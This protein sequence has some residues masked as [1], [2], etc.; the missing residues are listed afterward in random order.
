MGYSMGDIKNQEK[1]RSMGLSPADA[2]VYEL[3]EISSPEQRMSMSSCPDHEAH[4]PAHHKDY[5]PEPELF[6]E[7]SQAQCKAETE[8]P[9][10]HTDYPS[11]RC[12][13]FNGDQHPKYSYDGLPLHPD[14]D[15]AMDNDYANDN[16]FLPSDSNMLQ[17]LPSMEVD[18]SPSRNPRASGK[19]KE[20]H[21]T[22]PSGEKIKLTPSERI[23][24]RS[25]YDDLTYDPKSTDYKFTTAAQLLEPKAFDALGW[26]PEHY[27]GLTNTIPVPASAYTA[28][29]EPSAAADQPVPPRRTVYTTNRDLALMVGWMRKPITRMY[30]QGTGAVH[31]DF[32]TTWA[33]VALLTEAQLDSIAEFY[34]QTAG[35]DSRWWLQYPCPLVWRR[36]E[37]SVWVKRRKMMEFIG[38][39]R[40]EL[41]PVEVVRWL[42]ELEEEVGRRARAEREEEERRE[43][44]LMKLWCRRG[45]RM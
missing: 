25:Y 15:L 34:H 12:F 32:P 5:K 29:P 18:E 40:P 17:S 9:A 1:R 13:Q 37:D 28:K 3:D 20:L 7:I 24:A 42:D 45:G 16:L 21:I 41:P 6:V 14:V 27:A 8:D 31:P 43:E 36:E 30:Q 2:I 38:I 26:S 22:M 10:D 33:G 35:W 39:R 19:E 11:C 4:P 23:Y 44:L